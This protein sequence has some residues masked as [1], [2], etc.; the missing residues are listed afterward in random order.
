[1]ARLES[2]AKL[3]FYPTPPEVVRQIKSMLRISPSALL[4]DTCCGEGEALSILA[5][6]LNVKTCGVELDKNRFQQANTRLNHVLWGD[7]IYEFICSKDACSL[8]WLNPPYDTSDSDTDRTRIEVQFLKRHWPYLMD[9]GVLVYIIP[10]GSLKQAVPILTKHCRYLT[11]LKFPDEYF[12]A[13][14][15]VVVVCTKGRPK[16][17]EI[18]EH[19]ILFQGAEEAFSDGDFDRLI[20]IEHAAD[21]HYDVPAAGN[22]EGFVFRSVRFNPDQC[23][24]KLKKSAVWNRVHRYLFPAGLAKSIRPLTSLREGHLA[25]LLAS[26]IMNG[27]VVGSDSRRFVVKGSVVKDVT[28]TSEE[29]E[30]ETRIFHTDRYDITVRAI[31]FD[32]A[33]VITIKQ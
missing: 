1:M 26:G 17:S 22:M 3:G 11:I 31:C 4:L 25:M 6:G 10:W 33:E 12:D 18:K 29:L 13:F 19:S 14:N 8:L 2:Q 27:E 5:E 30:K 24:E 7:A 20:T 16:P 28:I 23:A 15:Q 21:F 32:P 9:G